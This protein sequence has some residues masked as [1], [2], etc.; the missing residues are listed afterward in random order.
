MAKTL[1]SVQLPPDID[2]TKARLAYGERALPKLVSVKKADI[3]STRCIYCRKSKIIL[4]IFR[5]LTIK[6]L[7]LRFF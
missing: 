5:Q 4:T 3:N 2:P 6:Y 7:S 1:I